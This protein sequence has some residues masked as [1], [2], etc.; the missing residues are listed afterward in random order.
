MLFRSHLVAIDVSGPAPVEVWRYAVAG[1]GGF[2]V[3]DGGVTDL[4]GDGVTETLVHTTA[5]ALTLLDETGTPQTTLTTN[6]QLVL[7]SVAD[8]DGDGVNEIVVNMRASGSRSASETG[9][10][11]VLT[12]AAG[13]VERV[14]FAFDEPVEQKLGNRPQLRDLDGDGDSEVLV[15]TEDGRL[16]VLDGAGEVLWATETFG[17]SIEQLTTAHLDDDGV[18][19]IYLSLASGHRFTFSGADG[20]PLWDRAGGFDYL[21]GVADIDDDGLEDLIVVGGG[22]RFHAMSGATGD[23]IFEEIHELLCNNG[24]IMVADLDGDGSSELVTSGNYGLLAARS[25][26]SQMWLGSE[27]EGNKDL[28]S[29]L[30]DVDDDGHLDV[31]H[32]SHHGLYAIDGRTGEV[33][34]SFGLDRH[35]VVSSVTVADVDGDGEHEVVFTRDGRLYSLSKADGALEWVLDLAEQTSGAVV[36]DIDGDHEAEIL[37]GVPGRLLVIGSVNTTRLAAGE[38]DLRHD[39]ERNTIEA[40]VRNW[41]AT[42]EA[43]ELLRLSVNGEALGEVFVDPAPGGTMTA[44]VDWQVEPGDHQLELGRVLP[45]GE[46]E[47]LATR[48]LEVVASD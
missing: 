9:V 47:P 32:P 40:T 16:V 43:P 6:T 5:G 33:R 23:F 12:A 26:G 28:L 17:D 36:A 27:T 31:I 46:V 13:G 34:W 20:S 37:V 38:S 30:V 41:G 35:H 11:I 45:G 24:T 8:L 4:D 15:A 14:D 29:A 39:S 48:R 42:L 19:D 2:F 25:D 10:P 1:G 22:D 44:E 3:P 7:P 21:P 18:A